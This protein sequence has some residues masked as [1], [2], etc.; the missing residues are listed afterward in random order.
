MDSLFQLVPE[1][2]NSTFDIQP[3]VVS[4]EA[5]TAFI[6]ASIVLLLLL[7]LSK[8]VENSSL[9]TIALPFVLSEQFSFQS[10]EV[11]IEKQA[12]YTLIVAFV[13][14][15][16]A[17]VVQVF[18]AEQLFLPWF[19]F[20]KVAELLALTAG[21]FLLFHLKFLL[22]N[23]LSLLIPWQV[24]TNYFI[25]TYKM[26]LFYLGIALFVLNCVQTLLPTELLIIVYTSAIA[27]FYFFLIQK[28]LLVSMRYRLITSIYFFLYICTLEIVPLLLAAKLVL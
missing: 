6:I 10:Y 25:Y 4:K 2:I 14:L 19:Q 27:L 13:S 5:T 20:G 9:T 26:N 7:T 8:I 16:L 28:W 11:E 21:I 18:N 24:D 12:T 17:Y 22:F 1:Q 15:Q 3:Y 23:S